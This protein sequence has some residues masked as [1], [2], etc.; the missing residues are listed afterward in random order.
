M[1]YRKLE[2]PTGLLI[3]TLL[4][5]LAL[6]SCGSV[7]D[8]TLVNAGSL[9][10]QNELDNNYRDEIGRYMRA[11]PWQETPSSK[12]KL[13]PERMPAWAKDE[14]VACVYWEDEF[15]TEST[16]AQPGPDLIRIRRGTGWGWILL[17]ED[18]SF[19][20]LETNLQWT[21]TE[22]GVE[23]ESVSKTFVDAWDAPEAGT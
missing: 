14:Y 18:L 12:G 10:I 5:S 13:E 2:R 7:S 16:I 15:L 9:L 23:T 1:L 8:K 6:I 21:V 19:H 20:I 4:L 22:D 3:L 11:T 17:R